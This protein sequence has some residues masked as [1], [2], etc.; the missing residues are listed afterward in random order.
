MAYESGAGRS[1]AWRRK[2][3]KKFWNETV[4]KMKS[5]ELEIPLHSNPNILKVKGKSKKEI[6]EL[7]AKKRKQSR[8]A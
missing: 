7:L 2:E 4:P 6:E 1:E 8:R 3:W 5:G